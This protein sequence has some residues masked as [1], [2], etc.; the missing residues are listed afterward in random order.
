MIRG[1]REQG[2][3]PDA[4][5]DRYIRLLN[6]CI[7]ERPK[8]MNAG[9]HLCRGNTK[10]GFARGGYGRIATRLFE[11]VSANCFYV[12]ARCVF[13]YLLWKLL[14]KSI[15]QLEYDTVRAGGFEPLKH[16]PADKFVVLGIVS[17]RTGQVRSKSII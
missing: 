5:L 12:S 4:L 16:L 10:E 11:G 2:V 6:D 9:V 17:T 1:M 8:D 15:M 7:C 13:V 3:D 14:T